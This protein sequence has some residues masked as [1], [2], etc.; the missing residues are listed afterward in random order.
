MNLDE[1]LQSITEQIANAYISKV[2]AEDEIKK[3]EAVYMALK[4]IKDEQHN[5]AQ[6]AT[7]D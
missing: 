5:E 7:G 1:K 2:R 4:Q 3:L 6:A